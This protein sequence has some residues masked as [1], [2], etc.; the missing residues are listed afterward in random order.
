MFGET[1]R[2]LDNYQQTGPVVYP[3]KLAND[4]LISG[5]GTVDQAQDVS[6][7][8]ER[9]LTTIG[10]RIPGQ[11]DALL[12]HVVNIRLSGYQEGTLEQKIRTRDY[13]DELVI[14]SPILNFSIDVSTSSIS[15][16]AALYLDY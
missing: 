11:R 12:N 1:F 15:N 10:N 6:E 3:K 14:L 2:D 7:C 8:L 9:I 5:A 13:Y 16:Q 4:S